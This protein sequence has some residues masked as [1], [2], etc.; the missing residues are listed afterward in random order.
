MI[1]WAVMLLL[2]TGPLACLGQ[3][4]QG[5]GEELRAPPPLPP[6][7]GRIL[8]AR[9]VDNLL[10]LK[11]TENSTNLATLRIRDAEG[12]EREVSARIIVVAT[13]TNFLNIY[14][15]AG[16]AGHSGGMRLTIV[17]NEGVPN[18]Y[19]LTRPLTAN[20]RKLDAKELN[21]P[22]SGSDFWAIDLGLGFLH[23]PG[24]RVVKKQMRKNLFCDQLESTNATAAAGGY[25]RVDSWVAANRPDD[26]I[27]V[28]ADAYD[29]Q[30]RLLKQFDPKKV[31]KVNGVWQ[32]EEMEIRNRQTG[33]RTRIEFDLAP[34]P[35]NAGR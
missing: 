27:I 18:D 10:R 2:A 29:A 1:K 31:E 12:N 26:L 21:T 4:G 25:S 19:F 13:P 11:P 20:P 23:W 14:E 17:H 9:L 6:A 16:T 22:F 30:G 32:L 3:G 35:Q 24:Q 15:T 28:H 5:K 7:E 8:A 33:T 34:G